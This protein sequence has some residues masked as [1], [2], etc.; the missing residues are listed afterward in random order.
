MSWKLRARLFSVCLAAALPQTALAQNFGEGQSRY[1]EGRST[2][3]KDA[4]YLGGYA[5]DGEVGVEIV[6]FYTYRDPAATNDGV[7]FGA[8]PFA[9]RSMENGDGHLVV[10][11]WADGRTCGALHGV[12]REFERLAP[13][14]FQVPPL[15]NAPPAG[16][17]ALGGPSARVHPEISSVWGLARQADGAPSILSFSG[18]DGLIDRWTAFAETQ[19]AECWSDQRPIE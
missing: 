1:E 5:K 10:L 7:R 16:S 17:S 9:R 11:G 6:D 12:L 15:Y 2:A 14:T 19:L 13:P 8:I 3:P 18:S 4:L